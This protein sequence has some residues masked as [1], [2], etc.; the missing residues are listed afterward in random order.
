[1]SMCS[2]DCLIKYYMNNSCEVI[3]EISADF[4]EVKVYPQL[5]EEIEDA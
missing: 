2:K 1:M 3:R 5:N 4:S